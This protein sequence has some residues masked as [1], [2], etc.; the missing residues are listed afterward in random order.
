MLV[1]TKLDNL[2]FDVHEDAHSVWLKSTVNIQMLAPEEHTLEVTFF[3][4]ICL[5]VDGLQDELVVREVFELIIKLPVL[6]EAVCDVSV[7]GSNLF[8]NPTEVV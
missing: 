2:V 5:G 6:L 1:S 3:D 7:Q 8:F 4:Q